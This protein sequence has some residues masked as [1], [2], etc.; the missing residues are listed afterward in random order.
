MATHVNYVS[1]V[2]EGDEY[3]VEIVRGVMCSGGT[4][5]GVSP[6]HIEVVES[7]LDLVKANELA[8]GLRWHPDTYRYWEPRHCSL[9]PG[10]V[11][12]E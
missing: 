1:I 9:T 12:V 10:G 8:R 3:R 5:D 7:N 2:P 4:R 6:L 11:N